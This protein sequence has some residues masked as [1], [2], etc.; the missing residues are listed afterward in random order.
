MKLSSREIYKNLKQRLTGK[1]RD[2]RP[3][4]PVSA[5]EDSS[6]SFNSLLPLLAEKWREVPG[7]SDVSDR[8]FTDELLNQPD[9]ELLKYWEEQYDT[10]VELRGWWWRLYSDIFR[11]RKVL[12]IGSGMGFDAT[13][14]ASHGAVWTCCDIARPNLQLIERVAAAKSLDIRTHHINSIKSFDALPCD[15]DFVWCNGSLINLPFELARE[16]SAAILSHLKLGGRWIELAYPRERWV[17]EGGPPFSEWGKLTDGERTPWVEWYD[18]ERLKL[19]LH[20]GRFQTVL[21][22]R[23]DS[24]HFIWMDVLYV[25]SASAAD[26][27]R[28]VA[29][30]P[31]TEPITTPPSH[32]HHAWSMPLDDVNLGEAITA[33]IICSVETGTIG[34][35]FERNGQHVSR[36]VFAEARTGTQL[37]YVT[38]SAFGPGVSLTARNGSALGASRLTIDSISLRPMR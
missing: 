28:R 6:A 3:A 24:D 8:R 23:F 38:T 21:E 33:E 20:P 31:P 14:F 34:L 19:R 16:E 25:G 36:E 11:N 29:V 15:F 27:P 17:R 10:G 26:L 9:A 32:W 35:A 4:R 1:V 12:E 2:P 22:Y 18:I 37:L 13:F 7:G 5:F 30:A